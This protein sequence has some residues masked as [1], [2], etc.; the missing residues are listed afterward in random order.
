M[1]VASGKGKVQR[2]LAMVVTEAAQHGESGLFM[3]VV[4]PVYVRT[5]AGF[6]E[7]IIVC[8]ARGP[9]LVPCK[10]WDAM[11]LAV[12][13]LEERLVDGEKLVGGV[14]EVPL[15]FWPDDFWRKAER[16]AATAS[17]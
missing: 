4:T 5:D 2:R 16:G 1:I 11:R 3:T 12:E 17:C 14:V 13:E 9:K 6:R 15:P 10:P 8:M 7:E